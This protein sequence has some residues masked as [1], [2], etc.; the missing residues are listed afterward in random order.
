ML[1]NLDRPSSLTAKMRAS[2]ST[3][4]TM[5]H[6][7]GTSRTQRVAARSTHFSVPAPVGHPIQDHQL[8]QPQVLL[9]PLALWHHQALLHPSPV[10]LDAR[11]HGRPSTPRRGQLRV[12]P[13]RLIATHKA[14]AMAAAHTDVMLGQ[15]MLLGGTTR[16]VR[17][18]SAKT[19]NL[20]LEA[21]AAAVTAEAQAISSLRMAVAAPSAALAIP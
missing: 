1:R 7:T 9:L 3:A 15:L 5:A 13:G 18:R 17:S 11:P 2:A 10:P 14:M 21:A 16:S 6:S 12:R 20:P 19:A 8:V 4:T